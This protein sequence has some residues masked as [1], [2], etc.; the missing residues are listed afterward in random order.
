LEKKNQISM[1]VAWFSVNS[2]SF[3]FCILASIG[4]SKVLAEMIEEKENTPIRN[5][6]SISPNRSN[7]GNHEIVK[8][9]EDPE[10]VGA[11]IRRLQAGIS[12]LE[13]HVTVETLEERTQ[14]AKMEATLRAEIQQL[15]SFKI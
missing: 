11:G 12:A 2:S 13:T 9:N 8:Q 4:P 5:M 7:I 3:Q 6:M 14:A 10:S 1:G 15:Y